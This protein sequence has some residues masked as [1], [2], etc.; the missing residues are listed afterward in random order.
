MDGIHA[1]FELL[2]RQRA[3]KKETDMKILFYAVFFSFKFISLNAVLNIS[4][5]Y[6]VESNYIYDNSPNE[7]IFIGMTSK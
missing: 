7:L 1:S 2:H 5:H 4:I 3:K 6:G